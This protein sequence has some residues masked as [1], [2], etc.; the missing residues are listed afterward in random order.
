MR[1]TGER[2]ALGHLRL[3]LVA[4]AVV[5]LG[6][7]LGYWALGA[8]PLDA[9]YQTVTEIT[10]VGFREIRP[11]STGGKI[12]SIVLILA[13]VGTAL[14]A[15]GV[16]IEVLIEGQLAAIFGRR[17]MERRIA[18]MSGH[19]VVCGWGR[20]GRVVADQLSG[21]G[22]EF[23]V[24]DVEPD[25]L[26]GV[27]YATIVG[28]ATDD[29]VLR[30]AGI[31]RARALVTVMSND[32]ANLYVTLSGRS[33]N[34]DLFIVGRA[35]VADSEEK[36]LRAGADR[37]VNP[38]AIGGSR[39]AAL[40]FQP[41]VSEFLDV[42][43]HEAGLEFRLEELRLPAGSPLSGQ[44]LGNSHIRGRTGALVLA[45]RQPDGTFVTNPSPETVVTEDQVLIVIGTG[46]QLE[47]LAGLVRA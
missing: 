2:R 9:V 10:T 14:Y 12:F 8:T 42:V 46:T 3:A 15:L 31:T 32:A 13:G 6:G 39:I 20:V 36:I 23:V 18:G 21:R 1:P 7:S 30:S 35:R 11:L 45:L 44:T 33:L 41:H 37:V 47:D 28:D 25:R 40:L 34:P 24:I 22:V 29:A 19:V 43:T 16:L 27:P 5:V 38:Q 26:V 4:L 17:R